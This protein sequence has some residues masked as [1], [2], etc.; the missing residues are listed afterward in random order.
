LGKDKTL[1]LYF[2][3][4]LAN[5]IRAALAV[6]LLARNNRNAAMEV[7]QPLCALPPD[8]ALLDAYARQVLPR[9]CK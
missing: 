1:A 2:A 9:I 6:T 5:Q 4:P 3:P 7:A 8:S